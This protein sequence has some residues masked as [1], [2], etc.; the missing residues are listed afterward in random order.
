MIVAAQPDQASA[1]AA[2]WQQVGDASYAQLPLIFAAMDRSDGLA[3]NW[4]SMALDRMVERQGAERLPAE[5]FERNG[6][7]S[8]PQADHQEDG[9][10]SVGPRG[11]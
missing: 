8:K 3:V 11:R 4:I 10:G 6:A 2:A 9:A 5:L 7:G 1:P